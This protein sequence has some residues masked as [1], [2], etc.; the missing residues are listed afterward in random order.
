[1]T[2][3]VVLIAMVVGLAIGTYFV[4]RSPAFWVDMIT[5]VVRGLVPVLTKRMPPEQ[6]AAWRDCIRRG[7][8][9]DHLKKR[10]DKWR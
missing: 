10:C 3:A 8:K 4:A 5:H 6:E 2:E 9:W 7:G 1:M